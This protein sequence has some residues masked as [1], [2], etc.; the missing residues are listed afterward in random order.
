MT[1][2]DLI[3]AIS[4]TTKITQKD[5]GLVL[6]SFMETVKTSL[7]KGE[8]INLVGFGNFEVGTRAARQARNFKTKE[9]MHIPA[10]K[11]VK[12]KIGKGL[13]EAVS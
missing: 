3:K 7:S 9:I 10:S 6:D 12:F 13:K 1:K 2:A 8:N 5:V 4:E 11:T